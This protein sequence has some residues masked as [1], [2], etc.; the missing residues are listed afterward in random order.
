VKCFSLSSG[1]VSL[2]LDSLCYVA[3]CRSHNARHDSSKEQ[4]T[5][6]WCFAPGAH[7]LV[8]VASL[9]HFICQT[10]HMFVPIYG[11]GNISNAH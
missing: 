10:Y 8:L 7:C 5:V 4:L 6:N 2:L 11:G 9:N 3:L 1:A